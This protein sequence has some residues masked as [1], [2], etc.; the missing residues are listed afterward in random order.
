MSDPADRPLHLG[1]LYAHGYPP[2][3]IRALRRLGFALRSGSA[4]YAGAQKLRFIDL[5]RPP[6]LELIEVM[7]GRAYSAFVPAGMVPYAPGISL[8][9]D[10]VTADALTPFERRMA[11]WNPYRLRVPYRGEE[12]GGPGWNYLNFASP[13]AA[14]TFI[15]L[16]QREEPSPKPPPPQ[17]HPNSASAVASLVFDLP[18]DALRGLETLTGRSFAD[19]ILRIGH[20]SVYARSHLPVGL[21]RTGKR[22]A[23][24]AVV[25]RLDGAPANLRHDE[26][27]RPI[28][29]H[30][31]E[32]ILVRM[33]PA[34]WDLILTN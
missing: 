10:G 17:R 20:V 1:T 11:A 33:N 7:D 12:A 4:T 9:V 27:C 26:R 19:G 25:V 5:A 21:D 28:R 8:N 29:W 6:A 23:L 15:Y 22:F 32:T 31:G 3:E 16:T 30:D 24:A 18:V 13:L 2:G 14:D 34:S